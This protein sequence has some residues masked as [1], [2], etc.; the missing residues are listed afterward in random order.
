MK[1]GGFMKKKIGFI[2]VLI[3][4]FD[5]FLLAGTVSAEETRESQIVVDGNVIYQLKIE[6]YT[7]LN[8]RTEF[9]SGFDQKCIKDIISDYE[10]GNIK[11]GYSYECFP[12]KTIFSL[13]QGGFYDVPI[14]KRWLLTIFA[15][16]PKFVDISNSEIKRNE[17]L[18]RL[19]LIY[20]V[21]I[22]GLFGLMGYYYDNSDL[23]DLTEYLL[24]ALLI[25]GSLSSLLLN[26]FSILKVPN[27]LSGILMIFYLLVLVIFIFLLVSAVV[28]VR[29][30]QTVFINILII[31]SSFVAAFGNMVIF[32]HID[33]GWGYFIFQVGLIIFSCS[34]GKVIY[35]WRKEKLFTTKMVKAI[36]V[37]REPLNLT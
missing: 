24:A 14:K 30:N 36:R 13:N 27:F 21:S 12:Y 1:T 16:G 35:I 23:D 22:L 4:F 33:S 34:F 37:F 10:R 2:G 6:K 11:T 18:D 28:R 20:F 5:I 17:N 7:S 15:D 8:W 19:G 3:M 9:P 26:S 25:I 32:G 29:S 31:L